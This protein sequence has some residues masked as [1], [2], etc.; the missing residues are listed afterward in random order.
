LPPDEVL[1]DKVIEVGRALGLEEAYQD[2]AEG[3]F[4]WRTT[5]AVATDASPSP[6]CDG[7]FAWYLKEVGDKI[8]IDD[9]AG[10]PNCRFDESRLRR[11]VQQP[12]IAQ[13]RMKNFC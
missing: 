7:F 12:E 4:I 5:L 11:E 3:L 2:R 1:K 6:K 8:G 9:P 13:C 10:F